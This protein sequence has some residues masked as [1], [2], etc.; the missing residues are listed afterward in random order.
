MI[1]LDEWTSITILKAFE[2][3]AETARAELN[4]KVHVMEITNAILA[5]NVPDSGITIS[6]FKK[7][8]KTANPG[9]TLYTGQD[10]VR[11]LYYL[12]AAGKLLLIGPSFGSIQLALQKTSAA[13]KIETLDVGHTAGFGLEERNTVLGYRIKQALLAPGELSDAQIKSIFDK[14]DRALG[15]VHMDYKVSFAKS[16]S[17]ASE[18]VGKFDFIYTVPQDSFLN[19]N[20]LG[21]KE[22]GIGR[23]FTNSLIK[24]IGKLLD[25]KTSPS[26]MEMLYNQLRSTFLTGK[27]KKEKY[28]AKKRGGLDIEK[29]GKVTKV[30]LAKADTTIDKENVL[31]LHT[32]INLRLHDQIRKNMG[33]G[34]SKNVL[35]YRTGRFAKSAKA[36]AVIQSRQDRIDVFYSYQRYPYDT[37][38]PGGRLFKPGR[39]PRT[40]IGRSI[41][42][43]ATEFTANNFK[44][45]PVLSKGSENE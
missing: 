38:A 9:A 15:K 5:R 11:K 31:R 10:K 44:V 4:K 8:F 39:N 30:G 45:N 17:L 12:E 7:A 19:R 36:E 21:T 41:R 42:Q 2:D 16:N 3:S 18:L 32:L 20:I 23:R 33:K 37:F 29:K 24:N 1:G 43:L 35:N 28:T 13:L 25:V 27:W 14:Y 22:R 34:R 40:I 6:K 26:I